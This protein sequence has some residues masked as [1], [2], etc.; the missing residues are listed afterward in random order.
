MEE[1]PTE[2]MIDLLDSAIDEL[3]KVQK[4][5]NEVKE[6]TFNACKL[7]ESLTQ[8]VSNLE[9]ENESLLNAEIFYETR[10]YN[11]ARRMGMSLQEG[12]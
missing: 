11:R 8:Q 6:I 2:L 7:V 1:I 3:A 12:E 9:S 5:L 4:R 10:D